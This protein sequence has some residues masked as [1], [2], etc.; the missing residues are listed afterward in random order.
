MLLAPAVPEEEIPRRA[1]E[2]ARVGDDR[3]SPTARN[4]AARCRRVSASMRAPVTA[5]SRVR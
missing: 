5:A 4:M 2:A 3:S 1:L